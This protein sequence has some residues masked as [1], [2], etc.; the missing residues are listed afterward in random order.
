MPL[1][2]TEQMDALRAVAYQGLDTPISI[3]RETQMETDFGS[4]AVWA[5]VGESVGWIKEMSTSKVAE[6]AGYLGTTGMFRLDA[7]VDADIRPGDRIGIEGNMF[8]VN[9]TNSDNTIRVFCKAT[10]RRVE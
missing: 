8:N 6:I 3:L 7:P 5:T 10:M 9:D 2:S 1:I 4:E